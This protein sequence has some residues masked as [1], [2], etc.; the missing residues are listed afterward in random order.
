MKTYSFPNENCRINEDYRRHYLDGWFVDMDPTKHVG[1]IIS[2]QSAV[3]S[4]IVADVRVQDNAAPVITGISANVS[5]IYTS[6]ERLYV[7]VHFNEPVTGINGTVT[8]ACGN[9]ASVSSISANNSVPNFRMYPTYT[10]S[11]NPNGGT[12]IDG[13]FGRYTYSVG[14]TLPTNIEK[15]G[16]NFEG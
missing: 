14:A 9:A 6:G 11:L 16:H 3:L 2:T 13:N 15:T 1:F 12:I 8:D 5:R 10:V 4:N 7:A